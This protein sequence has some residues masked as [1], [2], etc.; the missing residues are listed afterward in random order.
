[1]TIDPGNLIPEVTYANNSVTID[2]YIYQNGAT[3]VYPYNYAIINTPT[4]TLV[5]ST[6]NPLIPSAQ[7]TMQIDTSQLFNSPMLVTKTLTQ[8]GGELEFNPGITFLDSVVY[9]WRVAAAPAAGQSAA[10]AGASFVYIDP[11]HSTVG[12]NQSHYF[13]H[14]G[15]TGDSI[16]MAS[17][18]QWQFAKSQ[19]AFYVTNG[20]YPY[21]SFSEDFEVGVDGNNYIQ[22]ACVGHSFMFNVFN[23]V[24]LTAWKDVDGS[25]NNLYL[26]GS[27]SANCNSYN[28]WDFEFSYMTPASREPGD[29]ISGQRTQWLLYCGPELRLRQ[30]GR[31][32]PMR[33][34]GRRINR[35]TARGNSIYNVLKNAGFAAIDSINYPRDWFFVYKKSDPTFTPVWQLSQGFTGEISQNIYFN[36]TNLRRQYFVAG[37]RAGFKK[38]GHGALAGS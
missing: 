6:N 37:F 20:M 16:V 3:P 36:N 30:Y 33:P 12:M 17:N 13:Q 10:W 11:A 19:H 4:A 22:S 28:N 38:W 8:I 35:P 25:G 24:T 21:V 26:S 32:I 5:A 23:P 7:Y 2:A 15:S 9:Y 29:A 34:P 14:L 18:R 31:G 1:M 27:G